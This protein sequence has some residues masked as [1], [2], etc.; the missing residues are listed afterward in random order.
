VL[1]D[2]LP[3]LGE[4]GDHVV[5]ERALQLVDPP[6]VHAGA[7][8]DP[9]GPA[10]RT[11]PLPSHRLGGRDLHLEPRA[12]AGRVVEE[13]GHGRPGIALDQRTVPLSGRAVILPG[14]PRGGASP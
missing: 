14:T 2:R 4:E 9:R 5:T 8:T 12:V 13:R 7:L 11:V 6:R 3:H 10:A 1:P